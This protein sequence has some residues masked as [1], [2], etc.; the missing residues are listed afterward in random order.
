MPTFTVPV[1]DVSF[2]FEVYCA[3]CGEGLCR[4]T[5]VSSTRYRA[6]PCIRVNACQTCINAAVEAAI[7]DYKES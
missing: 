3:T 6:E 7:A 4:E 2:D 1:P 5:E